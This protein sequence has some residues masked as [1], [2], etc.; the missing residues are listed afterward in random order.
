M[1]NYV[2]DGVALDLA[3]PYAVSS[4]GGLKVGAIIAIAAI[5]A[6]N[7]ATVAG[8]TLG[9]FDVTSD[10]GARPGPSATSSIGTTRTSASRR[11]R[12]ATR[13]RVMP[14]P[15]RCR[16]TSSGASPG[17]VD[18]RRLTEAMNPQAQA[19]LQVAVFAPGGRC[20]VDR[21]RRQ[22]S[23]ASARSRRRTSPGPGN[24]HRRRREHPRSPVRSGDAGGRQR[25]ADPG[26]R[27]Q[28]C[29]GRALYGQRRTAAGPQGRL[30]LHGRADRLT[31]SEGIS[32][33]EDD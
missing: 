16:P 26:R 9:V 21:R 13:R 22:R 3:A 5:D 10:T 20:D 18:L 4:G 11:R 15:R 1:K 14:S 25:S 8:Y 29:C 33:D 31:R 28:P 23:G 27:R 30:D 19:R 2:H 12:P 17:A 24:D 7:G 6:A 32:N